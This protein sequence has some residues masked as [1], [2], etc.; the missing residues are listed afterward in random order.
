M[1]PIPFGLPAPRDEPEAGAGRRLGPL[2]DRVAA[3]GA[4][5]TA[6]AIDDEAVA[7]AA[8]VRG[9]HEGRTFAPLGTGADMANGA[10]FELRHGP[11]AQPVRGYDGRQYAERP[12]AGMAG[13]SKWKQQKL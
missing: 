5:P 2:G 1:T 7:D 8:V 10:E 3:L 6:A 11:L 13:M 9:R 12:N 4:R